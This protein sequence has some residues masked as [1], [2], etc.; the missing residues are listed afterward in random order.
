MTHSW[1]DLT[2]TSKEPLKVARAQLLF[3]LAA[4]WMFSRSTSTGV[5]LPTWS[6][7]NTS[8]ALAMLWRP[9]FKTKRS[10]GRCE[11]VPS[12]DFSWCRQGSRPDTSP[13]TS[14]ICSAFHNSR[15]RNGQKLR[16]KNCTSFPGTSLRD[17]M[18][19]WLL[20]SFYNF[21]LSLYA[22]NPLINHPSMSCRMLVTK[23]RFLDINRRAV[24]KRQV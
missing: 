6:S 19:P 11:C 5:S 24:S 22:L 12:C 21:F 14:L 23:K 3:S 9:S 16:R 18:S 10:C 1:K 8:T 13:F 17:C 2:L 20:L 15:D 4:T 7:P